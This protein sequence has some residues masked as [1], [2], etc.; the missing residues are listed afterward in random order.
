[1]NQGITANG[2]VTCAGRFSYQGEV[3]CLDIRGIAWILLK[4]GVCVSGSSE[5]LNKI[6]YIRADAKSQ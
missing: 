6:I 5:R 2:N 4:Q 3:E 1:M